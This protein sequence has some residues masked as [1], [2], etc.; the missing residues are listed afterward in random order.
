M[1]VQINGTQGLTFDNGSKL[2]SQLGIFNRVIDGGFIIN[3]RGYVTNT[4]LSSGVYAHDRWK[5]SSSGCT[6]TFTQGS[7]GVNTTITITAG[8]LQQVIEGSNM[9]E[10]GT[11]TLSWTGTAQ[12]RVNG[13]SYSASPLTTTGLTAGANCTI[14]FN[15]GT[16]GSVQMETGASASSFAFRPYGTELSLCQ[17]YYQKIKMRCFGLWVNATSLRVYPAFKSTLRAFPTMILNTSIPYAEQISAVGLT[18]SG[19]TITDYSGSNLDG[20]D[21]TVNGF[22]GRAYGQFA[23]IDSETL[24]VSAEL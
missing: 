21:V 12:A 19:S 20:A 7:A 8:S 14:E 11:Y 9:P 24:S 4:A 3:Q 18:G 1:S 13:G 10:G 16:V 6:Y 2:A 15:T 23:F 17:R 22:S 5:A